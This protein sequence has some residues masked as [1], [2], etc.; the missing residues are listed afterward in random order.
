MSGPR[1]L[2]VRLLGE[3]DRGAL[4]LLFA[5]DK[6]ARGRGAGVDAKTGG[7]NCHTASYGGQHGGR[8]LRPGS[9]PDLSPDVSGLRYAA[10]AVRREGCALYSVWS[11]QSA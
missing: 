6:A 4:R 1:V 8:A 3:R 2:V 7:A 9:S 5:L 11:R 10:A